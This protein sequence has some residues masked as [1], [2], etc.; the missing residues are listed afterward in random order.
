MSHPLIEIAVGCVVAVAIGAGTLLVLPR[1]KP[2]PE[3]AAQ[4]IVLDL[5]GPEVV[6]AE[7]MTEKTEAERVDELQRQLLDLAAEQKALTESVRAATKARADR[8]RHR[9]KKAP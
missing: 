2:E 7:P 9:R 5:K 8:D 1:A 4:T 3:P 6:R